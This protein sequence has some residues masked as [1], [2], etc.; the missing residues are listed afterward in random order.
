MSGFF[1]LK[2]IYLGSV[3]AAVFCTAAAASTTLPPR[4]PGFWQTTMV[5]KML[6]NG[7][8]M[9]GGPMN[10]PGGMV[11]AQCIDP[12]TDLKMM[13]RMGSE[14]GQACSKPDIEGGGN[15]FTMSSTCQSPVTGTMTMNAT[16]TFE[17]D[18]AA[19]TVVQM[20]SPKMTGTMTEDAHWL[21]ACP[22]GVVPGDVGM[23]MNGTFRKLTNVN[24][25]APAANPPGQ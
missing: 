24:D 8:P 2:D 9:N 13:E 18:T 22:A 5:M 3:A 25:A 17:S 11:M 10:A 4:K 20:T 14:R 12:K 15:N 21:G 7:Q 6:V 23:M 1:R 16:L 19:H